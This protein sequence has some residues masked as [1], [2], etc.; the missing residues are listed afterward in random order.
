MNEWVQRQ[1]DAW[2]D[3]W[4]VRMPADRLRRGRRRAGGCPDTR[5]LSSSCG[6]TVFLAIFLAPAL[7]QEQFEVMKRSLQESENLNFS[8]NVLV[9]HSVTLGQFRNS[10]PIS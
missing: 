6:F 3:G 5:S 10:A 1:V 2:T 7:F 9:V 8:S 4:S